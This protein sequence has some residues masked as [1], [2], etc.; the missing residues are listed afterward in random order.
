MNQITDIVTT[1]AMSILVILVGIVVQAVK[2][3]L[4]TRGGKKA[5]EVAEILANNAVNATEQVAGALDIHG[6]DKMEH[7]KTSLIEGLEAYNI[8]LTNDQL[9]TFIEAA[10][11]K[12]NEQWKK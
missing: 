2:K 12:A 9:N 7:A 11:K 5:L 10:V 4:L 1:S 3:Y 6:K 8:N